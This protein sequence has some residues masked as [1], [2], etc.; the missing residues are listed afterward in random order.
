MQKR[1]ANKVIMIYKKYRN[2]YERLEIYSLNS[3]TFLE[4][5]NIGKCPST[6]ISRVPRTVYTGAEPAPS[7]VQLIFIMLTLM[8][9]V[10]HMS[11][12]SHGPPTHDGRTK[13]HM[14]KE[15][16]LHP[17]VG[18]IPHTGAR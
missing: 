17:Q 10:L 15:S 14:S 11:H 8:I 13:P 9:Q 1:R 16:H 6:H 4:N 2:E 7:R 3:F 5:T 18:D 12:I